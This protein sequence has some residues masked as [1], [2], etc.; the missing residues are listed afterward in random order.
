MPTPLRRRL[1]IARR[2]IWYALAA[3]LVGM[4]LVAGVVSQL[5]PLA[6]RHPERI[7]AWLTSRAHRTV[8]FDHVETQW[9]RRGPL[10]RLDGLRI[11]DGADTLP[12]GAAE[13]LVSQY[14][15]LLPGRSFTELRLRGLDLTL[16][17][18]KDGRWQVRGLPGE[19]Q[20]KGDPFASLEG[21]GELQVIG[22]KLRIDAPDLGIE[23]QIPHVD[24]RLRVDGDRVRIGA[25]AWMRE[26]SGPIDG[27][28]IDGGSI[29]SAP[30]DAAVDLDRKRGDGRGYLAAKQVDLAAWSPLLHLAGV[31]VEGGRG[32]VEAW[33]DLRAHHVTAVTVEAALQ[34]LQL[35]GAAI[36]GEPAPPRTSFEHTDIG[37]RWQ[38][39]AGGWR[40]DAQ[41]LRIGGAAKMQTLDGFAIAGG[42]RF[43]L[44]APRVDA[45][46]AFAILALSDRVA[47]GLRRWLI[48]GKPDAVLE[49][50]SLSGRRGGAL[51]AH[52][53][54]G[55]LRFAAHGTTP[56]I[57]G[58][59]GTV[60]G[61]GDGFGFAF[62]Q[63]SKLRF[64][65][66]PGFGAPH[67][68][69]LSGRVA[70]WREGDGWQVE[71]PALHIAGVGYGADVR[72]GMTFQ[73][74]GTR[75]RI[76]L[77]VRLD[78]A[79]VPIAKRF[80]VRNRMSPVSLHWLDTAL[81]GGRVLD[82]RA[83]VSGD[84]DDWPFRSENGQPAKGIFEADARLAGA[85][86]KFQ[87]EWPAADH[88]DGD[89]SFVAD[90][91]TVK[92]S[93][94]IAG[95]V[96]PRL[97]AGIAHFGGA[98]L[99]V[100]ADA[101][102]DADKLLALLRQSPLRKEHGDTLDNLTASGPT[103]G[104]FAMHLP[105]HDGKHLPQIDG[106]IALDGARLGESRWKLAFDDVRGK[107]A[108]DG[109]GFLADGLAAMHDGQPGRL[110][111]RAGEGHVRDPAQAFE[112]ELDA[113]LSADE[114]LDHAPDL[115]WLKPHVDGRS[116]WSIGVSIAKAQARAGNV[117][118]A[119]NAVAAAS[120]RLQLRSTLV[121]TRLDLPAPLDK[122]AATSLPT[123]VQTS[124]PFGDSDITV[125]FGQRLALRAR[126][127]NG[128]SG[129]RVVL[130][131]D[132]VAE[133][134]PASGLVA[135]G[136]AATLDAI[137]WAALTAGGG[138]GQSLP[139]RRIDITAD[140]LQLLG[141]SFANTR[142]R[143]MPAPGGTAV[144]IN[145][146]AL[147]GTLTLPQSATAAITGRFQRV[148]WTAPKPPATDGNA[149]AANAT[150]P[151]NA[152]ASTSAN[153]SA[154]I[155]DSLDPSKI[156]ALDFV[157][158]DLH[159]GDAVLGQ[160][161]VRTR[162][163]ANGLQFDQ[164]QA[165]APKQS[166]DVTGN[167]LGRGANAR[168]RLKAD[169]KS[170]DFGALLA[171]F[172]FGGRLAS[173]DGE[174]H[175]DATWPGSPA[176]FKIANLEGAL[177]LVVKDGRLVEV[178]PGAGRVLGLLSV[179]QLP[180]RLMLD[181]RDFF[182]KGFAF[183]RIGGKVKFIAGQARSDDMNIEGPAAEI[184]IRGSA[185]L[186]AQ[187]FDQEIVVLPKSGNLLTVAGAI[188]GGPIG[189]AVGAVANAVLKKPLGEVGAKTYHV[190]GPWKDPK[191]EVAGHEEAQAQPAAAPAVRQPA[192]ARGDMP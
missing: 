19:Q 157:I 77:A 81:V 145:G 23:A 158:D 97:E 113:T 144:Q 25:R 178:E 51:S 148:Y 69:H 92:G 121:G 57:S 110:S 192:G 52:A 122:A 107:A 40:L 165:R 33:A 156:P 54:V 56:G 48:A 28:P 135:S 11:G 9:T 8:R 142:I 170:Q 39:I 18:D 75:P 166:V 116:A 162:P 86:V 188:A 67:D 161:T 94:Q 146:D 183:N 96:L 17:H 104:S 99:D 26:G 175:L 3:L 108:Y 89:V 1:R 127:A 72:G 31:M 98:E 80:W 147:A 6:E 117:A 139:L 95:V 111:L 55:N 10:L 141:G 140:K 174:A 35:Q 78:E 79:A 138:S 189:A 37:A 152:S 159:F 155:Q 105:L 93:G 59:S 112:A 130:G 114:L 151:A 32:N 150:A 179:A 60:D 118:N 53:K 38:A 13:I 149:T 137:D 70:G 58:L 61:D 15:G 173:G 74:D 184:R 45:G 119:A 71:T 65:W 176:G 167:W 47:P 177:S 50:V 12:I 160:A 30:I 88:I 101:A 100:R 124:L 187:T 143:A 171:G 20:S 84:L 180:R 64:D 42:Q 115:A 191:V 132:R 46:P 128:Q 87:P 41:R 131:S 163:V 83:L 126:S 136:R 68:V 102:T 125:A 190:T 182:S 44:R 91:F 133:A 185:D 14:A 43:A 85:V 36:P 154:N 49:D 82:G 168:T 5:L 153:A 16:Q 63:T 2:G 34:A 90:G 29:D 62:D 172:G 169:V 109:T 129:I 123:T 181:F 7:A 27:G 4:A 24:V 120:T 66:A 186:R 106:S 103:A 21:L 73:G 134:P 164:L 22:G 76:D